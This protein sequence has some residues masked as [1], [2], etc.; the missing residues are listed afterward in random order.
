MKGM[1]Q[2]HLWVEIIFTCIPTASKI[3]IRLIYPTESP[4]TPC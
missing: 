2:I 4:D 3:E 1:R